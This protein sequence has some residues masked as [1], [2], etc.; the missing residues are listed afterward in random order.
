[1]RV[2]ELLPDQPAGG[3]IDSVHVRG[4][5]AEQGH[6]SPRIDHYRGSDGRGRFESPIDTA[7][8]S[9]ERIHGAVLATDENV[10]RENRRLRIDGRR[11]REAKRPPELEPGNT[12]PVE[13]RNSTGLKAAVGR[14]GAPP[15]PAGTIFD[16]RRGVRAKIAGL[17]R[18][19]G[20]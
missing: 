11:T 4:E 15:V 12:L 9:I 6:P 16:P 8:P 5:V 3:R 18:C 10:A 13:P 14:A 7:G 2:D 17:L 20:G 1:M 19:C